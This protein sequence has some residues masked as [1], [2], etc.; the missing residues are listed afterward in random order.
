MVISSQVHDKIGSSALQINGRL[1]DVLTSLLGQLSLTI[2]DIF[3]NAFD[4]DT[5]F[6]SRICRILTAK[7]VAMHFSIK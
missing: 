6:F 5:S 1:V 7:F 4:D 3:A 2:D